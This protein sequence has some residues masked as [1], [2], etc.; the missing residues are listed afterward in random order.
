MT[1]IDGK[2]IASTIQQEVKKQLLSYKM[3]RPCLAV[4][5]VGTH[6]P[7][8]IYVNKKTAACA[9]VGIDSIKREMPSTISEKDLLREIQSLNAN[10][11]V[12]GILV[13]MPLP[14]H[15]NA[16][17]IMQNI[18]PEKDVDGLNPLNVGKLLLGEKKAFVPC[19]PLGIQVLLQRIDVDV[20]G[21]HVVIIGRSNLV[22]K[23]LAALLMQ[24]APHC[25]ATVTIAHSKTSK[26]KE[27]TKTGD[28]LIAA[29]GQPQFVTEDMVKD[30]VVLIDVGIN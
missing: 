24:N 3:R 17:T 4:L 30:G 29:I 12:D 18:L 19:T 27:I 11:A 13:Q 15:I 14:S 8:L 1:L 2:L 23:P 22:G 10:A 5:I 7:S 20:S 6:A 21:K 28:I 16:F 26:L 25:N 9:E